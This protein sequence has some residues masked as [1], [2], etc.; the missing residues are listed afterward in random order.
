MV[1]IRSGGWLEH[2]G[3]R[4]MKW[5][6]HI[7]GREDPRAAYSS[8][9]TGT[10]IITTKIKNEKGK[11]VDIVLNKDEDLATDS[12]SSK[13]SSVL[14]KAWNGGSDYTF[15]KDK[16][17]VFMRMSNTVEEHKGPAFVSFRPDDNLN[18]LKA[19]IGDNGIGGK[20]D[21]D[22]PEGVIIRYTLKKD[23]KIASAE[24]TAEVLMRTL[25]KYAKSDAA[26]DETTVFI[27]NA[28][29]NIDSDKG[30]FKLEDHAVRQMGY[31]LNR[32]KDASAEFYKEMQKQ[33]YDGV[34]DLEDS[35]AYKKGVF[36]TKNTGFAHAPLIVFDRAKCF[37]VEKIGDTEQKNGELAQ[38]I[39][40][41]S[42][43]FDDWAEKKGYGKPTDTRMEYVQQFRDDRKK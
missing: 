36:K 43:N 12:R 29:E 6:Q 37:N 1:V 30:P 41:F 38:F 32:H 3:R 26:D 39:N 16:D 20:F 17:L 10:K 19:A 33:G 28:I 21:T 18:Y 8:S 22:H 2:Y 25:S 34:F 15:P 4:G 9:G 35:A 13:I 40:Q 27:H 11:V 23:L 14:S 42:M 24:K 31:L 7:F 5:Y